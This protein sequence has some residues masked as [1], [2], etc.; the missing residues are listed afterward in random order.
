MKVKLQARPL[1]VNLPRLER[2]HHQHGDNDRIPTR[3]STR[4]HFHANSGASFPKT[5]DVCKRS[6]RLPQARS[7]DNSTHYMKAILISLC[8]ATMLMSCVGPYQPNFG[9]SA[10]HDYT[11]PPQGH[12]EH[13]GPDGYATN[14]QAPIVCPIPNPHYPSGPGGFAPTPPPKKNGP[15]IAPTQPHV[16]PGVKPHGTVKHL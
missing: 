13:N 4:L 3:N 7:S 11:Q 2:F 5:A 14:P 10:P 9:D 8:T 12:Y 16:N 15:W 6:R 1:V